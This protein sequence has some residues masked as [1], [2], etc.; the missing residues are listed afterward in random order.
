[1]CQNYKQ[2]ATWLNMFL[3]SQLLEKIGISP[4]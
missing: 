3:V 4:P 1:M 2:T